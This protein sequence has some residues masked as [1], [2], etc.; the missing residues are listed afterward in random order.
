V[1]WAARA[2][3]A[4]VSAWVISCGAWV[5]LVS[6]MCW[7]W[8]GGGGWV[9]GGQY[10]D[11]LGVERDR[12]GDR[13]V[14]GYATV[15]EQPAVQGDGRQQP[16][17]GGGGEDGLDRGAFGKPGLLAGYQVPGD[18]VQRDAGVFQAGDLQVV[19]GQAA[20]PTVGGQA[21]AAS[22]QAG[23]ERCRAERGSIPACIAPRAAPPASTNAVRGAPAG[24]GA[25]ARR[26][27]AATVARLTGARPP[28]GTGRS[29]RAAEAR[30]V[31]GVT[32]PA[33]LC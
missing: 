22:C 16:G 23:Q 6:G 19:G 8:R 10:V 32:S 29:G 13:G 14:V 4:A 30:A 7:G 11:A 2:V 26:A 33:S 28:S 15:G 31:S 1:S 12:V 18:E 27:G 3:L 5:K 25:A 17:D 24:R 21:V 20:Q 9:A